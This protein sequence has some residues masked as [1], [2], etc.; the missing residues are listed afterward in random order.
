MTLILLHVAEISHRYGRDLYPAISKEAMRT[1]V[2]DY[3]KENW[4]EE[5]L[6]SMSD[7]PSDAEV[8][9]RYFE[10]SDFFQ[11][12]LSEGEAY[13]RLEAEPSV[14]LEKLIKA[15]ARELERRS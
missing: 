15:A 8:V 14:I 9:E 4:D 2:A 10:G 1:Q 13:L 6:G 7:Y 12:S 11:E 5:A 3:C